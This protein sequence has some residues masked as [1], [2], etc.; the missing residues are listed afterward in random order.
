MIGAI[1]NNCNINFKYTSKAPQRVLEY[2]LNLM[3]NDI[4]SERGYN[5]TGIKEI[6]KAERQPQYGP[7]CFTFYAFDL[8]KPDRTILN[9]D[10]KRFIKDNFVYVLRD[11]VRVYPYGEKGVDWLELDKKRSTNYEIGRAS[12][13]ERV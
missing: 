10:L 3:D 5:L 1:D 7:F 11:G 12:C 6:E 13:R 4:L 8:K 9:E 2:S